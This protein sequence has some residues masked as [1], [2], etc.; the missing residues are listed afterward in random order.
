[1]DSQDEEGVSSRINL[2]M[3]WY[4]H[5]NMIDEYNNNMNNVNIA[6]KLRGK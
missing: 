5:L 6:D 3:V 1:M 2:K 4:L